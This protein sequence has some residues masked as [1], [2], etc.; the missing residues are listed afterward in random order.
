M[1]NYYRGVQVSTLQLEKSIKRAEESRKIMFLFQYITSWC[2]LGVAKRERGWEDTDGTF[3][4]ALLFDSLFSIILALVTLGDSV[5]LRRRGVRSRN[6]ARGSQSLDEVRS[7]IIE[8][9]V[10]T[11]A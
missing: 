7:R 5:L 10:R 9:L 1:S 3:T 2:A 6:W 11:L 8:G 4:P